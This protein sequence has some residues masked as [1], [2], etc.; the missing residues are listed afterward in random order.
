MLRVKRVAP[1]QYAFDFIDV[2][3]LSIDGVQKA[4]SG[5]PGAPLAL[6]PV[7]GSRAIPAT[8]AV[9]AAESRFI[10]ASQIG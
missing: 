3:T 6:A 2:R 5:H 9:I 8:T 4:N 7:D 1:D 10:E